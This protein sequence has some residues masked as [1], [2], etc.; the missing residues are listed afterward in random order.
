MM[1]ASMHCDVIAGVG[2]RLT[3]TLHPDYLEVRLSDGGVPK[4][5]VM[6]EYWGHIADKLRMLN[7]SRLLVLD[8]MPGEVL[9][10]DDLKHFLQGIAPLGL[11]STRIAYVKVRLDQ[12]V[13]MEV[14][15]QFA[16]DLGYRFRTFANESD[17]RL[18]LSYGED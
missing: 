2:Y 1:P 8:N 7:F 16:L 18:W 12:V 3:F 6:Q 13:N 17:A 4:V 15:E 11:Q 10:D 14:A 9:S 5:A